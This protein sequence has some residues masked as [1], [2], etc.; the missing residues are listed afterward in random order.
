MGSYHRILLKL[1][2]EALAGKQGYGFEP[3]ALKTVCAQI[4]EI[5]RRGVQVAIVVGGGNIFRGLAASAQG[6]DRVTADHMGMLATIINGL[7]LKDVLNGIGIGAQVYSARGVDEIV[8]PFDR[9]DA[10]RHLEAGDI[11]VFTGGTGNPFFSTDSAASLRA[12]QIEAD[13]VLKGTKVDGV[14]DGDPVKNPTAKKFDV[15]TYTEVLSRGLKVMDATA[16]AMCRDN[17]IP[18]RVFNLTIE[19]ELLR[20]INGEPVGTIVK[21]SGNG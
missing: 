3:T 15:I 7:A 1:S 16:I 14:Y 10:L 13:A 12:A 8:R 18:I 21:E 2:G 20:V 17:G 19:G 5:G 6:M 11:V 9:D 4:A